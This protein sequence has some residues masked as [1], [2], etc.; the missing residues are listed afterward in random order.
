MEEQDDVFGGAMT[1]GSETTEAEKEFEKVRI[2]SRDQKPVQGFL[3][4]EILTDTNWYW[5]RIVG[6]SAVHNLQ[7]S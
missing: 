4:H 5:P 6:W 1:I 7:H 2:F 3:V